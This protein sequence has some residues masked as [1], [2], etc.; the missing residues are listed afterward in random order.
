MTGIEV[1]RSDNT[2]DWAIVDGGDGFARRTL[3][4]DARYEDR[5]AR[6]IARAVGAALDDLRPDAV[7]ING[8]SVPEAR[9]ALKWCRTKGVKAILMSESKHDDK[10]RF[11]AKELIK[12]RLV[13]RFD[14][15]LV[16]GGPHRDYLVTLGFPADRIFLGYD[17]VDNGH[18]ARGALRA[19]ADAGHWRTVK[20]LPEKY[21]F[22]CTRFIARKNVSGVLRAYAAY[23][24]KCAAEPWGLVIAGSGA[25]LADYRQ[26]VSELT[27]GGVIWP[28][29]VQYEELP[30]YYGLASAFIHPALSEPWGLV[31]NEALASGL[32]VLC[33]RGTG[34]RYELVDEGNSGALFDPCS[35]GGMADAMLWLASISPNRLAAMGKRSEQIAA[36]WEPERFGQGLLAAIFANGRQ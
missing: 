16:G 25:E 20:G 34:A 14:A 32:P 9:A 19:R 13:G 11:R 21:F 6:E 17:V 2:Y 31:V 4:P 23:R 8:W 29:F 5:T 28:G 36:H 24:H 30:V 22:A 3:F 7:A 27:I 35:I 10:P 18:F 1:A 26:I 12:R 33:S 15:A